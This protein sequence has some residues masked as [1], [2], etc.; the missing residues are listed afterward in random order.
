[1]HGIRAADLDG[2]PP[3]AEAVEMLLGAMT[4]RVLVAH[5][6][7]VERAFLGPRAAPR[8][9]AAARPG[10]RHRRCVARL[11]LAERDGELPRS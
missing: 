10:R 4:G 3:L 2:A 8:R 7:D 9:R 5:H 1:M 11:W 6:A